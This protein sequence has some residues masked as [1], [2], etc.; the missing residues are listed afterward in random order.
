[1]EKNKFELFFDQIKSFDYKNASSEQIQGLITQ[2]GGYEKELQSEK[3]KCETKLESINNDI[4]QISEII[5]QHIP[6]INEISIEEAQ[7]QIENEIQQI[8][9]SL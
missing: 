1:M 3:V 6:N 9:S 4:S 5:K 8:A 7:S 2:A